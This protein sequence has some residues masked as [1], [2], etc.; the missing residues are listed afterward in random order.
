[1][2]LISKVLAADHGNNLLTVGRYWYIKCYYTHGRNHVISSRGKPYPTKT[3]IHYRSRW[4][5]HRHLRIVLMYD[6]SSIGYIHGVRHGQF[7]TNAY[8]YGD[9]ILR[10]RIIKVDYHDF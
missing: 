3:F 6:I 5:P 8:G 1:M 4:F 10:G 9:C 7:V 2:N